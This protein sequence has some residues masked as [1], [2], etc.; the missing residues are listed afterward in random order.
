MIGRNGFSHSQFCNGQFR[1]GSQR[2]GGTLN[3]EAKHLDD[4]D[5]YTNIH[6]RIQKNLDFLAILTDYF[7]AHWPLI[8][9]QKTQ[10]LCQALI[11]HVMHSV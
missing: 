8:F 3:K 6:R 1:R 9:S 10:S 7:L 11:K 2:V 4:T 5:R